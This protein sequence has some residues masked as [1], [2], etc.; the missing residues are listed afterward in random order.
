MLNH[1]LLDFSCQNC[2]ADIEQE[3]HFGNNTVADEKYELS[4]MWWF[5]LGGTDDSLHVEVD[6]TNF[7][8]ERW[9]FVRDDNYVPL[10]CFRSSFEQYH[11]V[12]LDLE[13]RKLYFFRPST[14]IGIRYELEF[15]YSDMSNKWFGHAAIRQNTTPW[16]FDDVELHSLYLIEWKEAVDRVEED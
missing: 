3:I 14:T 13:K 1:V 9:T 16:Q 4:K 6:M 7:G 5:Q 11:E 2:G 10:G 12:K 15:S 8:K